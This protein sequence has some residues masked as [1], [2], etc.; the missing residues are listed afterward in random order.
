MNPMIHRGCLMLCLGLVTSSIACSK[1]GLVPI[2]GEVKFADGQPLANG[3]VVLH[4]RNPKAEVSSWGL[5]HPDGSF[6]LGTFDIDD[7]VPPGRYQ[8]SIQN[9]E[10]LPPADWGDRVFQAQPLIH[11]RFSDPEQSEL[12]FEVP[13][14]S[15]HWQITVQPPAGR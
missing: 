9:A 10:S 12:T 15:P 11:P 3:R 8:V 1:T 7:G 13:G 2:Q 5:I 14:D 4:N 6:T